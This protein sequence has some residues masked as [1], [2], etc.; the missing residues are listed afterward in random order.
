MV[1]VSWGFVGEKY[2]KMFNFARLVHL[3][4]KC[5]PT[6]LYVQNRNYNDFSFLS[7]VTFATEGNKKVQIIKPVIKH[8]TPEIQLSLLV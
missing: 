7:S 2:Q 6:R 1:F 4:R 5:R 8:F 3:L